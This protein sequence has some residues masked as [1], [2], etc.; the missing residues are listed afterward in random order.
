M[1]KPATPIILGSGP[2]ADA[3]RAQVD[4]DP[5]RYRP[6]TCSMHPVGVC[7]CCEQ[8]VYSVRSRIT[9]FEPGYATGISDD[10]VLHQ[11]P[12]GV[13]GTLEPRCC[14]V[15]PNFGPKHRETKPLEA[16]R[17]RRRRS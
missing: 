7:P 15:A 12:T 11:Q 10:A 2:L 9:A 5:D 13:G 3:M 6:M 8:E 17:R 4:A 14:C 16:P 1:A